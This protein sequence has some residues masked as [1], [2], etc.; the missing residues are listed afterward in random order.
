M[1][2]IPLMEG[3]KAALL[4]LGATGDGSP[5]SF[6]TDKSDPLNDM[7]LIGSEET[8][9]KLNNGVDLIIVE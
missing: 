8:V 1:E 9:E 2:T 6:I 4:L 7:K 5:E 3:N